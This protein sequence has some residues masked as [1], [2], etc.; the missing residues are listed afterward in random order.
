[1]P[2]NTVEDCLSA[3]ADTFEK[4]VQDDN[5]LVAQFTKLLKNGQTPYVFRLLDN[6]IPGG[7][8]LIVRVEPQPT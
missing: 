5:A 2:T 8:M 3:T 7:Y 1:M 6:T 4:L